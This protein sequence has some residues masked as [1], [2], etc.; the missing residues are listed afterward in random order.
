MSS[1][2]EKALKGHQALNIEKTEIDNLGDY[3]TQR[4]GV[5]FTVPQTGSPMPGESA[6]GLLAQRLSEEGMPLPV[7]H[8]G[9]NDI[10]S[11]V[12]QRQPPPMV[13]PGQKLGG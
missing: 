12:S 5:D 8:N 3:L 10:G 1:V 11:L 7:A 6:P 2:W 4:G 9:K 13:P